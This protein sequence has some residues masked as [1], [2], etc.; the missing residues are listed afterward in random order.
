MPDSDSGSDIS[1]VNDDWEDEEIIEN[2]LSS[3]SFADGDLED[4]TNKVFSLSSEQCEPK[5]DLPDSEYMRRNLD[6]YESLLENKE[7]NFKQFSTSQQEELMSTLSISAYQSG[8]LV[9]CEADNSFDMYFVISSAENAHTSEVEVVRS[10]GV[11]QT[12]KVMTRLLRGQVFGHKFFVTS[13]P[14]RSLS[15]NCCHI[16]E[17]IRCLY[18][19]IYIHDLSIFILTII[20]F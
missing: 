19:S 12:E 18:I 7:L 13:I 2:W 11:G 16:Y 4:I 1:S 9:F 3:D 17:Y 15:L 20:Y 6:L 5:V 8:D 14:V 10:E